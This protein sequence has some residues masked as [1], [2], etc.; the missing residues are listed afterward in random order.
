[1]VFVWRT[2]LSWRMHIYLVGVSKTRA[3]VPLDSQA[4]TLASTSSKI[5][6][7]QYVYRP[8]CF[9]AW[10]LKSISHCLI[11]HL[12]ICAV[13]A[14]YASIFS[15]ELKKMSKIKPALWYR[16]NSIWRSLNS[17]KI[18]NILRENTLAQLNRFS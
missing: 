4:S 9:R 13:W 2:R 15:L 12:P 5:S 10:V 6:W 3:M 7:P 14:H 1:M 18:V 17:Q 16:D 8:Q 11:L